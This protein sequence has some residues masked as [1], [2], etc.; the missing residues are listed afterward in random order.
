M[1]SLLRLIYNI[2]LI[3]KRKINDNADKYL[4]F[5][6]LLLL[7]LLMLLPLLLLLLG[8]ARGGAAR[9]GLRRAHAMDG[10]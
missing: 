9:Y 4:P 3:E 2:K 8:A 7:L 6:L 10:R 5:L 1:K